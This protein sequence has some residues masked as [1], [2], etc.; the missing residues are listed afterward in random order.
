V[1][2]KYAKQTDEINFMLVLLMKMFFYFGAMTLNF[3][4]LK[5]HVSW[6]TRVRVLYFYLALTVGKVDFPT[7]SAC[8]LRSRF[9]RRRQLVGRFRSRE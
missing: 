8:N 4:A 2:L 3:H 7:C 6:P 9:L 5:R 1:I